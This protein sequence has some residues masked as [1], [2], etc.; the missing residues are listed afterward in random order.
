M[1]KSSVL[2][3]SSFVLLTYI[4]S[5]EKHNYLNSCSSPTNNAQRLEPMKEMILHEAHDQVLERLCVFAQK[6]ML[7]PG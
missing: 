2:L 6:N 1:G 5:T 4:E 7:H 3:Q